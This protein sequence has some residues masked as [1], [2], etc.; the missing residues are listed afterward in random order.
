MRKGVRQHEPV[1]TF[2]AN[3]RSTNY[4]R[5]HFTSD[6]EL[7][8]LDGWLGRRGLYSDET[9]APVHSVYKA[10]EALRWKWAN[11]AMNLWYEHP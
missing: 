6:R 1:P 9:T 8:L 4:D 7:S 11:R 3:F 2:G 10:K 5:A